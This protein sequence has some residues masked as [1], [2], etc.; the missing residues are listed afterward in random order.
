MTATAPLELHR[1]EVRPEWVDY[2]G[3]MNVAYY[4]LVFDQ[5]TDRLLESIGLD[6]EGRERH[7]GSVFVVEAHISYGREVLEGE[8]LG[9]STQVLAID[10]KRL[11]FFHRMY[12]RETGD[13]V[14]TSEWL[15]L[16][17]DTTARR[18]APMPEPVFEAAR[19]I[20]RA[21]ETL[22]WP[23]AAGRVIRVATAKSA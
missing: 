2:N 8:P 15:G 7:G 23:K 10:A 11:H 9:V 13:E 5:A 21:H 4:V 14:A 6:G 16:Y 12:H 3:H 17:V 20:A 22:P 19:E 1:D 18:A